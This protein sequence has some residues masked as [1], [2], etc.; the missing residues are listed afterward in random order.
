MKLLLLFLLSVSIGVTPC[1]ES[2]N[3]S[4]NVFDWSCINH[5]RFVHDASLGAEAYEI[6]IKSRHILIRFADD[7]GRFYALKTLGQMKRA[8]EIHQ[9][10]VKDAPRYPWRGF[11]LDEARHF[12][13]KEKV[14]QLLEIMSEFKLNR[15]HWHLA[16]NQGWRVEI[17]EYPELTE[18]GAVGCHSDA[19]APARY[20]TQDDIRE[21]IA[22][23]AERHIEV[24]PEIDMPGHAGAAVRAIPDIRGSGITFN[25][26]REETYTI[27]GTVIRELSRLF[28]GRYFHIGGDE[29]DSGGWANLPEVGELMSREQLDSIPDVQKYFGRRMADTVAYYGKIVAGWDDIV[30]YGID[31]GKAIVMWWQSGHP[32]DLTRDRDLGYSTVICPDWPFYLDYCQEQNHKNG[33]LSCIGRFNTMEDI[34]LYPMT[35]DPSVCG[36]QCNLWTEYIHNTERLD[37]MVFPRLIALAEKAWTQESN[38]NYTDFQTRLKDVFQYLDTKGVYY[39][40]AGHPELHPEPVCLGLWGN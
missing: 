39:Y 8:D 29:V 1:P 24:I 15:F 25:P 26:A 17:V 9:C 32:D 38:L 28:P 31:P 6:R 11:M 18:V 4:D 13:G 34:Y 37:Y 14:K 22:F 21:I 2:V 27:L 33:F 20:Y 40:D 35:D 3:V 30:E 12:H 7:A 10:V 19:Q 36:L 16:D 5:I 23:A